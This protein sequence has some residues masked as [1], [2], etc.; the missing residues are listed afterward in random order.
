MQQ[1]CVNSCTWEAVPM[2]QV[3]GCT[4]GSYL[5]GSSKLA[6]GGTM[7]KTASHNQG[8]PSVTTHQGNWQQWDSSESVFAFLLRWGCGHKGPNC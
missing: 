5:L 4:L 1:V 7:P 3:G 6:L 2:L 8:D